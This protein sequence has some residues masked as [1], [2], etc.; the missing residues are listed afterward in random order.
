MAE[1]SIL[2]EQD[3]EE[4]LCRHSCRR[5]QLIGAALVPLARRPLL[6][7]EGGIQDQRRQIENG[8]AALDRESDRR[9][10]V[11]NC[12][13]GG[14]RSAWSILAAFPPLIMVRRSDE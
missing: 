14:A 1:W 8:I 10:V 12:A 13:N 11:S 7:A 4:R 6:A 9:V 2:S 5:S 3:I